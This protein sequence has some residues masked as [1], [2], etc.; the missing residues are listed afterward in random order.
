[1]KLK[2]SCLLYTSIPVVLFAEFWPGVGMLMIPKTLA[3]VWILLIGLQEMRW[4][5][6]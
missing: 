6:Q 3:Y 1:M 4:R 5:E 2:K